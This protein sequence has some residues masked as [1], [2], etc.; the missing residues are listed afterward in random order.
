VHLDGRRSS[1]SGLSNNL[2][3]K[4]V[5]II[6]GKETGYLLTLSTNPWGWHAADIGRAKACDVAGKQPRRV[7]ERTCSCGQ[8]SQLRRRRRGRSIGRGTYLAG[9]LKTTPLVAAVTIK[10]PRMYRRHAVR[11]CTLGAATAHASGQRGLA[12]SCCAASSPS[13][14]HG[15]H[16]EGGRGNV[17]G[18]CRAKTTTPEEEKV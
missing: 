7:N 2:E 15:A 1:A 4:V 11:G 12:A 5:S 16:Q 17:G 3:R 10:A 18:R 6:T 14:C 8:R 9:V 13:S